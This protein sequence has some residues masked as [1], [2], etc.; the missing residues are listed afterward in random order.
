[1]LINGIGA[2]MSRFLVYITIYLLYNSV[3][4]KKIH[5]TEEQ[6]K[7]LIEKQISE[8]ILMEKDAGQFAI[9]K[10]NKVTDYITNKARMANDEYGTEDYENP[11]GD[12]IIR[13]ARENGINIDSLRGNTS[14]S[15]YKEGF[16]KFKEDFLSKEESARNKEMNDWVKTYLPVLRSVY[17]EKMNFKSG[18]ENVDKIKGRDENGNL[19]T[20]TKVDEFEKLSAKEREQVLML[21]DFLDK[22]GLTIL[23]RPCK[24]PQSFST[25]YG[26]KIS[27]DGAVNYLTPIDDINIDFSNISDSDIRQYYDGTRVKW[28]NSKLEKMGHNDVNQYVGDNPVKIKDDNPAWSD[29]KDVARAGKIEQTTERYLKR[30]YGMDLSFG[31]GK[32]MFSFGNKKI[33]DRTVIINFSSALRCPAWN[34]CLLKDACYARTTEKN[35]DNTFD[36]N[37]RTSLIWQQTENDE[38]LTNLMLELIRSYIFNY[39]AA[40]IQLNKIGYKG[41][42]TQEELSQYSISE[43]QSKFGDEV[44]DVISKTKRAD[45]VRLNEDG[46]FI[47]QWLVDVW[48][49]WAED[50]KIAGVTVAAYTCRA[51][52][53]EKVRN[54]IL[55]LSQEELAIGQDAPAVAR[56]FYAVEPED[57]DFFD[58]TY[59]GPLTGDTITP[60]YR[61]LI[62]EGKVVGYYYKC[63]CGRGRLKYVEIDR[64]SLKRN[65]KIEPCTEKEFL[66]AR[67]GSKKVVEFNGKIYKLEKNENASEKVDCYKCRI[68]YGRDGGLIRLADGS[69]PE[70]GLPK[71]VLVSAHGSASENYEADRKLAGKHVSEWKNIINNASSEQIREEVTTDGADESDGN[72]PIAIKQIVRNA[73]ESVADMMANSG[74]AIMEVNKK[75]NDIFKRLQI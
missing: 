9:N 61:P 64:Q 63:P 5:L 70:E 47:G 2:E 71:Y 65:T 40:L 7:K 33:D 32:S 21:R 44:I 26:L 67:K 72:S 68:C 13:Q 57:Y 53:Y 37:L 36:K 4:M 58:D 11:S 28:I 24:E 23:Y 1:M 10:L 66:G 39:R 30:I 17:G 12:N 14:K 31:G 52:N 41:K 20:S 43:L 45:V 35:Y 16:Q 69:N 49:K 29:L 6:L 8:S 38:T 60:M 19:Q 73:V 59:N 51:L 55:N 22:E 25:R 54:I 62:C 75:F 27:G 56:Y 48:D 50:F 18:V 15:D 74:S 3:L 34:K 42:F 46:D